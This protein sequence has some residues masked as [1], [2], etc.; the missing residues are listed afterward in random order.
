METL[1]DM[2]ELAE[3]VIE[4]YRPGYATPR[5]SVDLEVDFEDPTARIPVPGRSSERLIRARLWGTE[6]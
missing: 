3:P 5:E 6:D 1:I 4:T 2:F